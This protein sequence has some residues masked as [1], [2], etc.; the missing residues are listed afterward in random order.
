MK[1]LTKT[2]SITEHQPDY[3]GI[4]DLSVV[5]Y[6][7]EEVKFV[8]FVTHTTKMFQWYNLTDAP[9]D[10]LEGV[11]YILEKWTEQGKT[12]PLTFIAERCGMT[13]FLSRYLEDCAITS[14][15]R[16]I[17]PCHFFDMDGIRYNSLGESHMPKSRQK[18]IKKLKPKQVDELIE[19]DWSKPN[20]LLGVFTE[21]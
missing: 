6:H 3:D 16:V 19:Y 12:I 17:G 7:D 21:T 8:V 9:L 2:V 4:E 13:Q 1:P 10:V 5:E 18:T 14:I 11:L 20:P 15:R